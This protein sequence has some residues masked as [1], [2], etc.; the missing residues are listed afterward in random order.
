MAGGTSNEGIYNYW[1]SI[2][3]SLRAIRSNGIRIGLWMTFMRTIR[4]VLQFRLDH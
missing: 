2:M 1:R 4:V 3:K